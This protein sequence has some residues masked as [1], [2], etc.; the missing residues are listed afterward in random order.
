MFYTLVHQRENW[1]LFIKYVFIYLH[2]LVYVMKNEIF[3][4]NLCTVVVDIVCRFT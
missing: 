3:E 2:K 4:I 1:Y